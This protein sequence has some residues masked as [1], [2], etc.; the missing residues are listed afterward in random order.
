[1]SFLEGVTGEIKKTA[2]TK[3]AGAVVGTASLA[4]TGAT[5]SYF[6]KSSPATNES[7]AVVAVPEV[8]LP[9]D[10]RL[11]RACIVEHRQ[12]EVAAN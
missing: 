9:F 11:V 4:A 1:M 6:A 5:I 3:I 12:D 8:L 2:A 10:G 7:V